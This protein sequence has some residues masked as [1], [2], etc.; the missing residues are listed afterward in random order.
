MFSFSVA[1]SSL[2]Q[3]VL[4]KDEEQFK[5]KS[6]AYLICIFFKAQRPSELLSARISQ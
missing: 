2:Q 3:L 1:E 4:I 5:S 6:R